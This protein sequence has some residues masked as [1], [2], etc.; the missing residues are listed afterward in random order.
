M[1]IDL[2]KDNETLAVPWK[3]EVRQKMFHEAAT[4]VLAKLAWDGASTEELA[5]AKKFLT[6]ILNAAEKVEAVP[7]AAPARL[8]YDV[9]REVANR[10]LKKG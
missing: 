6:A 10:N 1:P 9:E 2:F 3:D 7:I 4:H 5:G 8:N